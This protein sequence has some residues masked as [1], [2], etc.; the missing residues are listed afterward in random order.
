M[1]EHWG[2]SRKLRDK[3]WSS[4]YECRRQQVESYMSV[5]GSLGWIQQGTSGGFPSVLSRSWRFLNIK[6]L[7]S[8]MY[9]VHIVGLPG[10]SGVNWCS[11]LTHL[12]GPGGRS[13]VMV[14]DIRFGAEQIIFK[15]KTAI[16]GCLVI[17]NWFTL[18]GSGW[19]EIL[20]LGNVGSKSVF[21]EVGI[22]LKSGEN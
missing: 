20:L 21:R 3:W 15:Q 5:G 9:E 18:T 6:E 4:M 22:G 17:L 12:G 7:L 16:M 19:S 14:A 13:Y 11:C 2:S 10:V 1:A 8:S